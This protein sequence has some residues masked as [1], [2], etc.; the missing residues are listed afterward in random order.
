MSFIYLI[1]NKINGKRYVGQTS[2]TVEERFRNHIE[3]CYTTQNDNR[4]L[5]KALK[6]YGVDNFKVETLEECPNSKVN[7][8]EIYWI[9][10]LG[11]FS[12]EYNAT[13]GGD[14][15]TQYDYN[16]IWIKYQ[17]LKNIQ[18]TANYFHCDRRVVR[19][20]INAHGIK[21]PSRKIKKVYQLDKECNI[22]GEYDSLVAASKAVKGDREGRNGIRT[23]CLNS[24]KSAYGYKWCFVEDYEERKKND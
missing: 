12:K 20:V 21:N 19:S 23:A 22:L 18:Q 24:E 14:G 3:D 5:Y 7:E 2:K 16:A 9:K 13:L 10:K 1:T 17:E 4:P 11:T 8:R 15:Y 6:K